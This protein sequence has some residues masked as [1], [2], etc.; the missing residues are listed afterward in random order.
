MGTV[1]LR[2]AAFT[3]IELLVVVAIIAVLIGLLLPA[4]QM[5]RESAARTQCSNNMHQLGIALLKYH[6]DFGGFPP[7]HLTLPNG[8]Q[9]NWATLILPYI[10][11]ENLYRQYSFNVTWSGTANDSGIIQ[12]RISM[13]TCPSAPFDRHAANNR[14]VLDYPAINQI[15]RPNPFATKLPPSD[16]TFIG[17]LGKNVAR[18][19]TQIT[20]GTTSTLIL[21]EDA[22][23]N[24]CWEMGQHTGSLAQDGSWA[25]P[26]GAINVSGFNPATKST[27]GPVAVNGTNSQNVY[28]FHLHVAGGLFADGSIRYLKDTTSIDTLIALVTREGREVIADN[29]Y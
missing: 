28:S 25:N 3:L 11:L 17:V 1:S 8:T 13:Y 22:G 12:T 15:T 26:G 23:R 29:S 7:G 2:R 10:E 4:V 16:P 6:D 24:E 20:D 14:G 18:R 9:H 27:P 21:A 19:I 5:A